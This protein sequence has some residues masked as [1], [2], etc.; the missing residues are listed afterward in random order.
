MHRRQG[1]GNRVPAFPK[2][3][4]VGWSS[5]PR[6]NLRRSAKGLA[7]SLYT[8]DF[9]AVPYRM[10]QYYSGG[11]DCENCESRTQ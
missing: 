1:Q 4:T 6:P 3:A 5:Q 11:K 2:A 7:G 8:L 9:V 10:M